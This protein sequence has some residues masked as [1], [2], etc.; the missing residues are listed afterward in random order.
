MYCK[1]C[2]LEVMDEATECPKC[3]YKFDKYD[4]LKTNIN[5]NE[6]NFFVAQIFCIFSCI[7]T[8]LLGVLCNYILIILCIIQVVLIGRYYKKRGKISVGE[9]IVMLFF[10]STIGGIIMLCDKSSKR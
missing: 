1:N 10:V 4:N 2:H 9:K 6:T 7:I 3:G 8:L 5:K